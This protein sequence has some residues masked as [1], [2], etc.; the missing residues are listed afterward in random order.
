MMA[1]L[2]LPMKPLHEPTWVKCGFSVGICGSI[3]SMMVFVP[4]ATITMALIICGIILFPI[5]LISACLSSFN[6]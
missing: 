5:L 3:L 4:D 2:F 1:S 6:S